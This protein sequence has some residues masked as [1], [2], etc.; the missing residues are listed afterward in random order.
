MNIRPP[1]LAQAND[2]T[3]SAIESSADEVRDLDRDGI[4]QSGVREA[5]L[6]NAV[7]GRREDD[8]SERV[9][10]RRALAGL[11]PKKGH[12]TTIP[13][14]SASQIIESIRRCGCVSGNASM[15]STCKSLK[16]F[17]LSYIPSAS[18]SRTPVPD[19]QRKHSSTFPTHPAKTLTVWMNVGRLLV[20]W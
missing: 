13:S 18:S 17:S 7:N 12:K 1:V 20:A 5:G 15:S 19:Y 8:V 9:A 11:H 6:S 3:L 2:A 4:L 10:Y 16:I 14:P